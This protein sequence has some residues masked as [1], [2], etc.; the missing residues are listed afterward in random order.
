MIPGNIWF[1]LS[2]L[3][4]LIFPTRERES[5]EISA[6]GTL[7]MF[8]ELYCEGWSY[9]DREQ[10]NRITSW[11]YRRH[12]CRGMWHIWQMDLQME[13]ETTIKEIWATKTNV[14]SLNYCHQQLHT[15]I[16]NKIFLVPATCVPIIRL[17]DHDRYGSAVVWLTSRLPSPN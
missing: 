9:E 10:Y 13:L 3:V 8:L 11:S 6:M 12:N 1:L 16:Q 7:A 2:Q 5:W 17:L 15:N 4:F 14:N